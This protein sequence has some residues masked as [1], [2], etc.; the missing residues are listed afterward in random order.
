MEVRE[1]TAQEA[2]EAFWRATEQ[3]FEERRRRE[4]CAAWYA[5]HLGL[6]DAFRKLAEK[7]EAKAM[8]LLE[9]EV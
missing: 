1:P 6:S 8:E 5:H 4:S 7:H 9:E 3:R 2:L